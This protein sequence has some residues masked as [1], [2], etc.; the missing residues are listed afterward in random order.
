MLAKNQ[1][2]QNRQTLDRGEGRTSEPQQ[3]P[4]AT[5]LQKAKKSGSSF[6]KPTPHP[7][8]KTDFLL[9]T[10]CDKLIYNPITTTISKII[11]FGDESKTKQFNLLENGWT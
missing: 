8:N 2:V 4:D 5:L 10:C 7:E 9:A 6:P 1:G 11:I 3:D